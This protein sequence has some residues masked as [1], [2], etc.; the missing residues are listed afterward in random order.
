MLPEVADMNLIRLTNRVV[1]MSWRALTLLIGALG[2]IFFAV[3][4]RLA[5]RASSWRRNE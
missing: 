2:R 3:G 1:L 4:S 5:R